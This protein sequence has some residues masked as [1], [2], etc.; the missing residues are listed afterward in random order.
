[1][2][3]YL[4]Q[5][6]FNKV[7]EQFSTADPNLEQYGFGQLYNQNGEPKVDQKYKGMWC[8]PVNTTVTDYT[9]ERTYQIIIYDVIYEDDDGT[10]QNRVISDCEEIA[11]RLIRF[12]KTKSD[13]FDVQDFPIVTPFTDRWLDDVSGVILDLTIE[14]NGESSNCEDPDY[15]F[16][17]KSNTI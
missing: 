12:L 9:A 14:F 3:G 8:N 6:G 5:N 7:L 13:I 17:I 16:N 11:F 4:S 10:N 15:T 1:M 2:I